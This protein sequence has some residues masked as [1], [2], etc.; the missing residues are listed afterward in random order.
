MAH[1][2]FVSHAHSDFEIAD[3]IRKTLEDNGIACWIAPRDVVPGVAFGGQITDAIRNSKIMLLVFSRAVNNSNAVQNEVFLAI[4]S[5]VT[6]L[7][8]RIEDVEFNEE[9][10]FHLN[11][12]HWLRGFP[13]PVS[14]HLNNLVGSLHAILMARQTGQAYKTPQPGPGPQQ[15]PRPYAWQPPPVPLPAPKPDIIPWIVGGG[16]VAAVVLIALV[17][18]IAGSFDKKPSDPGNAAPP[19]QVADQTPPARPDPQPAPPPP[20]EHQPTLSEIIDHL[21]LG[22]EDGTMPAVLDGAKIIGTYQLSDSLKKREANE[23][24]FA[25]IDALG[26]APHETIPGSKCL[27]TDNVDSLQANY[28]DKDTQIVIFCQGFKCPES[29]S[30]AKAAVSVGYQHIFWYRGGINAW[31]AAGFDMAEFKDDQ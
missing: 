5:G 7:P 9:L 8:F 4:E 10:R 23:V 20:E 31:K 28:P 30:L 27:Q 29:F 17:L 16:S 15:P 6:V 21:D 26:C 12:L 2:V 11:R 22:T 19:Q 25:L 24:D 1:Q 14:M 3:S 18:A 13:P